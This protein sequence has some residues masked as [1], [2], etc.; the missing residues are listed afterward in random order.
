MSAKEVEAVYPRLPA[1]RQVRAK[2]DP[3]GTFRNAFSERY[4]FGM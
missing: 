3:A 4:V 1:F 2:L